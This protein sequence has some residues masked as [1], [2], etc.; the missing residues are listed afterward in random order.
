[1][2]GTTYGGNGVFDFAL[3]NLMDRVAVGAGDG[4]SLGEMFGADSDTLDFAQ[5]PPDY[6]T[7]P[8][9]TNVSEPPAWAIFPMGLVALVCLPRRRLDVAPPSVTSRFLDITKVKGRSLV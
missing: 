2:L 7:V 4:V 1:V 5:L 9:A 3:P 8:A 6:P